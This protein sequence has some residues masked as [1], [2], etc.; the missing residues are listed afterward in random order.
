MPYEE[1]ATTLHEQT[2]DNWR[3]PYF[4]EIESHDV[5]SIDELIQYWKDER[6]KGERFYGEENQAT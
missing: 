3:Q 1:V 6:A 2:L 4:E 5:E